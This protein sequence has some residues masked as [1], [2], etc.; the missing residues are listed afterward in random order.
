MFLV[1]VLVGYGEIFL[2]VLLTIIISIFT[3]YKSQMHNF[4]RKFA[5]QE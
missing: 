2:A 1:G 4:A 3:A 5:F